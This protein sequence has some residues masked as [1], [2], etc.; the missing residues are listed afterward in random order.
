MSGAPMFYL[1]GVVAARAIRSHKSEC[2]M[3]G[4]ALYLQGNRAGA[5]PAELMRRGMARQTNA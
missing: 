5:R 3:S 1:A 4:L 2:E